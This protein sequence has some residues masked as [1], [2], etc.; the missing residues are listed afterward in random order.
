MQIE[1]TVVEDHIIQL[2]AIRK[3]ALPYSQASNGE[4]SIEGLVEL[5]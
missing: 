3:F 1:L 4:E 2:W 5:I